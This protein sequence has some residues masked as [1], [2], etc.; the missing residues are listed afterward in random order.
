MSDDLSNRNMP[1]NRRINLTQ[2]HEVRYWTEKLKV[3]RADLEQAVKAAGP[4]VAA[5]ERYLQGEKANH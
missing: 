3:S 2:E 4:M 1:D 5:V